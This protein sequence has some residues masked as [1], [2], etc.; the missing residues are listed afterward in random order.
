MTH[1]GY[2]PDFSDDD[3]AN[4]KEIQK[5]RAA[6]KAHEEMIGHSFSLIQQQL[7]VKEASVINLDDFQMF[8]SLDATIIRS[9]KCISPTHE[10]GVCLAEYYSAF[11]VSR[12]HNGGTDQYLFGYLSFATKYPRTYIHRETIKEKIADIFLKRDVDFSVS[13]KF[14]KS[15]EVL[16]EDNKRLQD[17]L[18]LKP[19]DNLAKFPDMEIE[20]FNDTALFRTSRKPVSVEEA[21]IFCDLAKVLMNIF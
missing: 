12:A 8:E 3:F 11:P 19:L 10:V 9:M 13:A 2:M 17:L 16:T 1:N 20:L 15:F 18:Q 21:T 7:N 5:A 4:D 6:R 14:S